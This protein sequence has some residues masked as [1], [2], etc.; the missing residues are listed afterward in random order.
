M[1]G[2]RRPPREFPSCYYWK[3]FLNGSSYRCPFQN[4]VSV[5]FWLQFSVQFFCYWIVPL[6]CNW[7]FY[8]RFGTEFGSHIAPLLAWDRIELWNVVFYSNKLASRQQ[9]KYWP[10][11]GNLW[12][13]IGTNSGWRSDG[14]C[15]QE[16]PL[17]DGRPS[18]CNPNGRYPCCSALDICKMKDEDGHC[19]SSGMWGI[20]YHRS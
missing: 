16:Y 2:R 15:G 4:C 13:I 17:P 6:A 10:L 8:C 1:L 7:R 3:S 11:S 14:H 19:N 20:L 18:Q 12:Q 5:P 9:N